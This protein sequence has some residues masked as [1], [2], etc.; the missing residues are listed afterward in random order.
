MRVLLFESDIRTRSKNNS[1]ARQMMAPDCIEILKLMLVKWIAKPQD[2]FINR[3]R[4]FR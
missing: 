4:I 1:L 3:R 2:V